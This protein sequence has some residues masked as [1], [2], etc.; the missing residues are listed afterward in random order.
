M[1]LKILFSHLCSAQS[2]LV[3]VL[4][5]SQVVWWGY[6]AGHKKLHTMP[7]KRLMSASPC[8]NVPEAQKKAFIIVK[9]LTRLQ[10]KYVLKPQR[11]LTF[12][13]R[14]EQKITYWI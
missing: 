13:Q 8:L 3:P 5:I 14:N 9:Q 10:N 7:R 1:R 6:L 4:F 11:Y 2:G 12:R